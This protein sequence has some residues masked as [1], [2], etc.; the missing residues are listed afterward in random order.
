VAG[1]SA[2]KLK[3]ASITNFFKKDPDAVVSPKRVKAPDEPFN[4]Q[5]WLASLSDQQT[6]LLDLEIKTLH[7]SWLA[8]IYKELTKPYFLKLKDFLQKERKTHKVFPPAA[9]VY[10][11]SRHTPFDTVKVVILGQDPYHNEGQAHGLCFSVQAPTPPPPSLKNI[12]KC[13]KVEYPD[14]QVPKHGSLLAWA[15]RGVLL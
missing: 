5:S 1:S 2:K 10:A 6:E 15:D 9:D 13:L 14:F 7:E 12:Y 11:W 8:L 4:K 3:S